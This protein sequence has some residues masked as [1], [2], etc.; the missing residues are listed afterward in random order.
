MPFMNIYFRK[1]Y[2]IAD[3]PIAFMFAI[4]GL[5]MAIAQFLGPPWPTGWVRFRPLS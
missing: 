2:G 4:G 3:G 1:V 5:S